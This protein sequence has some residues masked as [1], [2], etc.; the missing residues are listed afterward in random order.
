MQNQ[1]TQKSLSTPKLEIVDKTQD[2]PKVEM[3][4]ESHIR[5][6]RSLIN[7]LHPVERQKYYDG[8]LTHLLNRQPV[9]P[10]TMKSNGD[11][12]QNPDLS[13]LSNDEL[14]LIRELSI[15]MEDMYR[16]IG[17]TME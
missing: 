17:D 10:P 15:K 11:A 3:E 1:G 5:H 12:D 2:R 8:F 6:I 9:Y 7:K 4:I 16:T 14:Q 13:V